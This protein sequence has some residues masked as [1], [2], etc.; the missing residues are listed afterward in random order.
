M[1]NI[2]LTFDNEWT[3]YPQRRSKRR[4]KLPTY[5]QLRDSRFPITLSKFNH[6]Q[7]LKVEEETVTIPM[8]IYRMSKIVIDC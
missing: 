3:D 1:K 4:A 6:L 5:F 2:K 7:Q 8:I